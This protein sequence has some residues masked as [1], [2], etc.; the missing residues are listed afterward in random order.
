MRR[1]RHLAAGHLAAVSLSASAGSLGVAA[2]PI[3]PGNQACYTDKLRPRLRPHL[4]AV[5][6]Q[7]TQRKLPLWPAIPRGVSL[8]NSHSSS[9]TDVPTTPS[10]VAVCLVGG[11]RSIDDTAASLKS[12]LLEHWGADAF[13][14]GLTDVEP[15]D[16]DCDRLTSLGPRVVKVVVG[17]ARHLLDQDLLVATENAP[18]MQQAL[19]VQNEPQTDWTRRWAVAVSV[20]PSCSDQSLRVTPPNLSKPIATHLNPS[21]PLQP[22]QPA[23]PSKP[24]H[25]ANPSKPSKPIPTHP[26]SSQTIQ[27]H[28]NPPRLIQILTKQCTNPSQPTCRRRSHILSLGAARIPMAPRMAGLRSNFSLARFAGIWCSNM[29]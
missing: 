2:A 11:L 13:I 25:H 9:L 1:R 23:D 28:Q 26:R 27:T 29:R 6:A 5:A 10:R 12:N 3:A 19:L 14:V 16:T 15:F 17:T 20:P 24:I 4:L 7:R 22:S 18:L 21:N 8:R